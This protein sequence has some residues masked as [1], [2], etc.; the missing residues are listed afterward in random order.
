M[1]V[2]RSRG[3]VRAE[4]VTAGYRPPYVRQAVQTFNKRIVGYVDIENLS[5]PVWEGDWIIWNAK[6]PVSVARDTEF[7]EQFEAV[8]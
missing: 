8:E 3:I 1:Q 7:R 5:R 4:Q 2:F 6:G